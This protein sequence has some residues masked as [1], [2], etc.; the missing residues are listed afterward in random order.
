MDRIIVGLVGPIA[1]GKGI[2]SE[3]LSKNGFI[4]EKLSDRVREE[5]LRR[6]LELTR[7]NL[8]DVG[9]NL[10]ETFG[11]H[12]LVDL[13]LLKHLEGDRP[14]CIDGIRNPGELEF[15]RQSKGLVIG[16]TAP[17]DLR[18]KWYL[19]RSKERGEDESSETSF[20]A[21]NNRDMGIGE[22]GSGQQVARCLERSDIVIENIGTKEELTETIKEIFNKYHL[23]A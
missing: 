19:E 5:T 13:T 10:R 4:F 11:N 1:S 16:I 2:V 12:I 8:Q 3:Y 15:L 18:L 6:G 14:I 9:N 21:A 17:T 22:G 23:S 7:K 20:V